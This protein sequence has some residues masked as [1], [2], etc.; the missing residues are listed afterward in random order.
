MKGF[1]MT[2]DIV[3]LASDVARPYVK[4]ALAKYGHLPRDEFE[5]LITASCVHAM[6]G[7]PREDEPY[8][9]PFFGSFLPAAMMAAYDS[10]H[11]PAAGEG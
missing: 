1:D 9:R 2:D 8:L 11:A 6:K 5:V 10:L 7:L 3:T 4:A